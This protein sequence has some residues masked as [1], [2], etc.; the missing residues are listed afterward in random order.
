MLP[1]SIQTM[2]TLR[3]LA[4]STYFQFTVSSCFTA[5]PLPFYEKFSSLQHIFT[6]T[7]NKHYFR[8][9]VGTGK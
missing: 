1:P 7:T 2:Q 4:G 3:S 8:F 6:A 5:P 9:F